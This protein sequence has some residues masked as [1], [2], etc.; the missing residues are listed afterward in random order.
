MSKLT[1]ELLKLAELRDRGVLTDAEFDT[2]KAQ[3][4]GGGTPS[5]PTSAP[6][7]KAPAQASTGARSFLSTTLGKLIAAAGAAVALLVAVSVIGRA[8]DDSASSAPPAGAP[9]STAAPARDFAPAPSGGSVTLIRDDAVGA[10]YAAPGPRRCSPPNAAGPLTAANAAAYV[11]CSAE[12]E[13]DDYLYLLTDV[14][15]D[16]LA[17]RPYDGGSDARDD[18]DPSLPVYD[19]AGSAVS[20]QCNPPGGYRQVAAGQACK[21]VAMPHAQG[22]CYQEHGGNWQCLFLD[23]DSTP[24]GAPLTGPP[25]ADR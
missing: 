19:I 15:I 20:Y 1:D 11:I 8:S 5:R 6:P 18:I 10:K 9:P 7:D 3:L 2:Q 17:A 23:K 13:H 24:V 14:R 16:S 22:I 21:Q 25:G 12:G 4:L